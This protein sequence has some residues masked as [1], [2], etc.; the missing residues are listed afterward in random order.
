MEIRK[1]KSTKIIIAVS[2]VCF[3]VLMPI[4][5]YYFYV[6]NCNLFSDD[7]SNSVNSIITGLS[8]NIFEKNF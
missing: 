1:T 7:A 8:I 4:S 6:T 3:I 5:Y 2:P